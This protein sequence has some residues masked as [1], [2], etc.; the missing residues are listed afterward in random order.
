MKEVLA[1]RVL[2]CGGVDFCDFDF[3]ESECDR[4]IPAGSNIEI[5][6]GGAAGADALAE[7]YA[8]KKGFR[9]SVFPAKWS[10]YGKAAG[11]IRNR[12]MVDYISEDDERMV[13]AFWNGFSRGTANTIEIAERFGIRTEILRY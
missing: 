2:I 7:I 5:V 11:P 13:I 12:K 1:V 8:R 6:A 9:L 10:R 4:L 3:L